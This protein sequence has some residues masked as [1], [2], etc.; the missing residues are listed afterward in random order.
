ME[1]QHFEIK[2]F[3]LGSSLLLT[4]IVASGWHEALP[5]RGSLERDA[6]GRDNTMRYA[7]L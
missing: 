7:A 5:W 4:V 6:Y 1:R 2:L 3:I